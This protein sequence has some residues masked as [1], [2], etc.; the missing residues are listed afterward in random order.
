MVTEVI[1]DLETQTFFDETGD[2]DPS[3]LGVSIVSLYKRRLDE[4]FKEKEGEIISYWED[5]LS[6]LWSHLTDA[7][8]IIGFNSKRF[9]VPVLKPYTTLDISKLP[10]LDILEEIKKVHG[11][12][13]SLNRIAKETLGE[14]KNDVAANAP[15]YWKKHDKESLEKLKKYCEQDVIV[16]KGIYDYALANK[17]LRF[18]DYWNTLHEVKIDLSYPDSFIPKSKQIQTSLF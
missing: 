5:D 2:F 3:K 11:K 16:T 13:V 14:S 9:D 10:H 18:K 1:F 12:R 8:R 4:N 7:D 17:L 15:L 6:G